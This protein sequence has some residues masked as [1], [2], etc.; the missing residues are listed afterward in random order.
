MKTVRDIWGWTLFVWTWSR[1]M[2]AS[3]R[4]ATALMPRFSS[5]PPV[6]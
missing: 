4:R 6:V 1:A 5:A 2:S 3:Q